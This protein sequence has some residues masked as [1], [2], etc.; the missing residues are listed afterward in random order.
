[1]LLPRLQSPLA[2]SS[3]LRSRVAAPEGFCELNGKKLVKNWACGVGEKFG[4]G[5][6]VSCSSVVVGIGT[7]IFGLAYEFET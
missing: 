7:C 5:G 3:V 2:P 4:V 1:V 6:N